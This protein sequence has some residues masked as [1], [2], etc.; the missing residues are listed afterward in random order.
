L[1]TFGDESPIGTLSSQFELLPSLVVLSK[2]FRSASWPSSH[3]NVS[4]GGTDF[5]NDDVSFRLPIQTIK[6]VNSL[7]SKCSV[8]LRLRLG[9]HDARQ[10]MIVKRCVFR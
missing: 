10:I 2:A 9:E 5:M 6:T 4:V 8:G 1:G 3:Q 7:W